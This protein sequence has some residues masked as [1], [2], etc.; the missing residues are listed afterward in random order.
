MALTTAQKSSEV[1]PSIHLRDSL[2]PRPD[3]TVQGKSLSAPEHNPPADVKSAK[4]SMPV[5]PTINTE[6]LE[7]SD[8]T[9]ATAPARQQVTRCGRVVKPPVRLSDYV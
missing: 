8:Q 2:P 5:T 9:P 3:T 6:Q 7:N 1:S 4:A